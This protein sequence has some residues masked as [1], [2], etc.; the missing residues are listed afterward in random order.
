MTNMQ[1]LQLK[2]VK[3]QWSD[4]Y[5]EL[6]EWDKKQRKIITLGKY[7]DQITFIPKKNDCFGLMPSALQFSNLPNTGVYTQ[8]SP[9]KA[10]ELYDWKE[11]TLVCFYSNT[12]TR[13]RCWF[14]LDKNRWPVSLTGGY[15][16]QNIE[17]IINLNT[18]DHFNRLNTER[19]RI[20]IFA[21]KTE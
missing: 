18:I 14:V 17:A 13:Q 2:S 9:N 7:D 19:S 16:L 3:A 5:P 12:E 11:A 10:Q 6:P 4:Q 20:W 1:T 8:V 21:S 15:D